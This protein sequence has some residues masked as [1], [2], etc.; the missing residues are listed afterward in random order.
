MSLTLATGPLS[1]EPAAS[2]YRI[3]GPENRLLFEDFPRRVRAVL[4]DTTVLDSRDGKLLHETGYLP[5]LY[6]PRH[7]LRADLLE[8]TDHATNC[9][10]KG[11]ASYWSVRVGDRLAENAV[12]AYERPLPEASWLADHMAVYWDRMDAWLDEEEPVAGHLRDPYHRVDACASSRHVR[13]AVDGQVVADTSRP[14]LLSETGEPNRYFVPRADVDEALL[15]HSETRTVC[16][17]IGDASHWSVRV[18]DRTLED[19]ARAY[20]A[21]A[22]DALGIAGCLWFA[23]DEVEVWVDGQR[24]E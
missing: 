3:E 11:D 8:A 9:P 1:R 7:D 6:V 14:V 17:Y 24:M 5:Q 20:E 22:G 21:P 23:G 12:W 2:N 10:F 18:G 15:E 13:V 4:A 19:V 16:P